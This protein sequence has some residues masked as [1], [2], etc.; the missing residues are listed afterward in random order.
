MSGPADA[1]TQSVTD[2]QKQI[3]PQTETTIA[4]PEPF[5]RQV[6]GNLRFPLTSPY[7]GC[8]RFARLILLLVRY[9]N[10]GD[11]TLEKVDLSNLFWVVFSA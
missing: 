5:S 1:W 2:P 11:T 7:H 3:V 10:P 6:Q 9:R 8:P 4:L